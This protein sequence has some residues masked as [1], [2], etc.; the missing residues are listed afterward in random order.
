MKY[1]VNND[2]KLRASFTNTI[3]RPKYSALVPSVNI[4]TSDNELTVGNPELKPTLSYNFDLSS[5]Y[6]FESIGLVSAGVFYKRI[7]DFIVDQTLTNYEYQ[8]VT[9]AKYH[10]PKNA[11][12][13]N[14]LGMDPGYQRDFG[15]INTALKC[16]GLYANYTYTYS[17]VSD[18]NFTGRENE[19]GLS[20][21]GSPKHTGNLSLYY[22]KKGLNA[23]VSYN[24]ASS[25]IDE[26]GTDKFYDRYYD[27]VAYLD[28]NVNYTFA[29]RYSVY[30][31]A[32]NLLNQPLR[33]YQGTKNR[34]MQVE[35]YGMKLNLAVKVNL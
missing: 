12:N 33:Y 25:F 1:N 32:T 4:N 24:W 5:D 16:L 2:F 11:G 19:S 13:A 26:M 28:A 15:F 7:N 29:K 6:Y 35:Y 3:A 21:P 9:Y 8:G 17:R 10:Q 23:R 30:M 31:E 34:T 18:F 27:A 22:E 20:L 14:V